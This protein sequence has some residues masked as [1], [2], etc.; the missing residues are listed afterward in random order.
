MRTKLFYNLLLCLG[1]VAGAC[2]QASGS[3][4]IEQAD[5]SDSQTQNAATVELALTGLT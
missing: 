2:G 4:Q 3:D 5:R 1:G